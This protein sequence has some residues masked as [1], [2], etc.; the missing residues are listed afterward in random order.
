M[1][2]VLDRLTN[3]IDVTNKV[4]SAKLI[5]ILR[6]DVKFDNV[7][8]LFTLKSSSE[9]VIYLANNHVK[10][11]YF[12]F[13]TLYGPCIVISERDKNQPDALYF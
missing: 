6:H 3:T 13:L 12:L 1:I 4:S 8:I 2:T 10:V 9:Y 7:S 11:H 5:R